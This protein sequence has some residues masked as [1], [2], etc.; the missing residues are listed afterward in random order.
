MASNLSPRAINATE[1]IPEQVRGP[2]PGAASTGSPSY[3]YYQN[4][5]LGALGLFPDDFTD[6]SV[7]QKSARGPP[8]WLRAYAGATALFAAA[9]KAPSYCIDPI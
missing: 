4:N 5:G 6:Y 7:Q 3:R 2:R 8:S 9:N 1:R